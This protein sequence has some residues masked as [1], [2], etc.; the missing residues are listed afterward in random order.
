MPVCR[1]NRGPNIVGYSGK[2]ADANLNWY[3]SEFTSVGASTIDINLIQLDDNGAGMV[4]WGDAMQIVGPLGS[5]KEIYLYWDASMHPSGEATQNY[6]GDGEFNPVAVSFD[7]GEGVAIDNPNSY[8]YKVMNSGEVISGNIRFAAGE[9]L[10]WSGN[11]FSAPININ[12][13]Q[14]DDNDAGMVAW[15]DAM[16]IVGPLGSAKEIY[17]YWDASMHPSG[18]A[19]Q[20]YWG[21]GEFNPVNVTL[22][23]G[24]GFAIDNPNAYTYDIIIE[25]PY[26]L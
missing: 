3:A 1:P 25:C 13:I 16:Q 15:G 26:S 21:D 7:K 9:N 24:D 14:L 5:A 12:A 6:W 11:P 23:P 19:T 20:N 18:E 4:A 2:N 22:Q 17:L 10:N 8:E